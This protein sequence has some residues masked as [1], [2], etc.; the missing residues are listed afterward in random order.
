MRHRWVSRLWAAAICALIPSLSADNLSAQSGGGGNAVLTTPAP[1]STLTGSNVT[2]G[3]SMGTGVS[4]YWLYVGTTGVGSA[5][6]YNALTGTNRT[7]SVSGLPSSGTVYVRLYSF[8]SGAGRSTTIRTPAEAPLV[9][10]HGDYDSLA[11]RS[12]EEL[13]MG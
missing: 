6:K 5:D 8:I 3:W 12:R 2:F 11:R 9:P 4:E 13:G 10:L 1:G 7:V